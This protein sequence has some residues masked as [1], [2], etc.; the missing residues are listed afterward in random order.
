MES[1][2]YV[3]L[4]VRVF[5]PCYRGLQVKIK[6]M[7]YLGSSLH[8]GQM[9]RPDAIDKFREYIFL[10]FYTSQ[11]SGNLLYFV[12]VVV[13]VLLTL[14]DRASTIPSNTRGCQSGTWSAG[15]KKIKGHL[16]SSNESKRKTQTHKKK[17]TKRKGTGITKYPVQK[18]INEGHS[19]ERESLT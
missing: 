13:V 16:P 17:T 15:Q 3:F 10:P 6:S 14:T 1:T 5:P 7:N 4:L 19:I 2:S 12:V 11:P 9:V 18:K 8:V